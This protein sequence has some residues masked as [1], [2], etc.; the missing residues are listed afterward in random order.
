MSY[1]IGIPL[2]TLLAIFQ[3]VLM[4]HIQLLDGRAD[5]VLL[6]VV[7][8]SL[9]RRSEEAMVWGVIGGFALDMLSGLPF[10]SN[11][12]ILLVV[13]FLVSF[14]EGRFWEAH[15]LMPLGVMLVA[16]LVYHFLCTVEIMILGYDL[17]LAVVF[18]RIILPSTF[19]N[20]VIALPASQ[21]ASALHS[22]LFPQ[23]VEL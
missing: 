6:A 3:S 13:A 15:L 21:L 10:G 4:S 7:S 22:R 1:L 8:W 12:L 20:V 2:L 16:S 23:E 18:R 9:T 11:A 19:L 14:L 17:S 5:L